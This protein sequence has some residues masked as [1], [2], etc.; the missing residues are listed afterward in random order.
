M[1]DHEHIDVWYPHYDSDFFDDFY[2]DNHQRIDHLY[3]VRNPADI[4]L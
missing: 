3:Q 4:D 2:C 1:P